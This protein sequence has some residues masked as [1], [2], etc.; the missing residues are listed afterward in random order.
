MLKGIFDLEAPRAIA[1]A[2]AR[3][4]EGWGLSE[5]SFADLLDLPPFSDKRIEERSA[6][7][8]KG[9]QPA[10]RA[11]QILRLFV[12]LDQMLGNDHAAGQWLQTWNADLH[13]R[14]IDEMM[15]GKGIAAVCE[16]VES[17]VQRS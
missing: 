5:H 14:P 15:S 1:K 17:F 10:R 7:F 8:T 9:S 2:M 6:E 16:H 3:I 4:A 13:C 11:G 12:A